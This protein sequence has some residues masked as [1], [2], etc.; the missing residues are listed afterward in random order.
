MFEAMQFKDNGTPAQCVTASDAFQWD[1]KV[2]R[3][4]KVIKENNVSISN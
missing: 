4:I 3:A 2:A 1:I